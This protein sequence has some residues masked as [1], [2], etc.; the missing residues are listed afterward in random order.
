MV[1]RDGTCGLMMGAAGGTLFVVPAQVTPQD[2]QPNDAA[3][4]SLV[5]VVEAGL[6]VWA[7]VFLF[8]RF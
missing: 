4:I 2:V 3:A 6:I 7:T 5:R 8:Q 1:G